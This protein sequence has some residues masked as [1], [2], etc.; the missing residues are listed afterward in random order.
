MEETKLTEGWQA[1]KAWSQRV[2]HYIGSDGF[3][4]CRSLGFYFGEKMKWTGKPVGRED[5]KRCYK[6]AEKRH[7]EAK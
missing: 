6:L 2:Y 4:L 5:C 3:S 7:A 1:E